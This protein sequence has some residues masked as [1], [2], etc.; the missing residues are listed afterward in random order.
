[1]KIGAQLYS[2]RNQCQ[3]PAEIREAFRICREA[4]YEVVQVSGIGEIDPYELRDISQEF[5]LPVTVTHTKPARLF[6]EPDAVIREHRIFGCPV[7]GL[8]A[9]PKDARATYEDF[10]AYV[11][12]LREVAAKIRDAGLRFAYHNHAFEFTPFPNGVRMFDYL[13]E[14]TDFD[15]IADVCWIRIGGEDVPKQLRRLKGRLQNAHLKDIRDLGGKDFC[16]LGDGA[17]DLPEAI[18]A[19]K[20]CG[21]EFAHVEQ[22]NATEKPDPF[23]EMRRSADYLRSLGEL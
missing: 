17:V 7:V 5:S 18:A 1:M 21:C 4:G 22:D 2:I 19:L 10:L 3:T 8:G 16:P 20:E 15:I 9:L 23:G 6:E 11:D 13:V 12:R 14:E